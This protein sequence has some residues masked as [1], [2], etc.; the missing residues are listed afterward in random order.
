MPYRRKDTLEVRQLLL[1]LRSCASDRCISRETGLARNTVRRYR[2]W[3][4]EQGLLSGEMPCDAS[5]R[6]LLDS[7]LPPLLPPQSVSSVAPYRATVVALRGKGVEMRAVYERLAERGYQGSYSSVYRFVKSLEPADPDCTVRVETPPGWEAQVDFG[8]VRWVL[9]SRTGQK[10]KAYAFVMTL[11][12]SR[13]LY[14]ETVFDQKTETWLAC[15]TRALAYFGGVPER[16]VIDNLKAGITRAAWEDPEVNRVYAEEAEHYGFLIA[17][18]RPKTPEH[19]GKV[20]NGVHFVQ[21]NFFAGREPTDERRTNADL[22]AWCG[23][24]GLRDH[25]TTHKKPLEVFAATEMSHLKALPDVAYDIAVMKKTKVHRDCYVVF[26]SSY[27]S[28]PFRVV[29]QTLWLRAG[30]STVRLFDEQHC[31]VATHPRAS[32]RGERHTHPDH[33]PPN[34][35]AGLLRSRDSLR[36]QAGSIGSATLEAV[37]HLLADRVVDK[38]ASAGRLLR[39]ADKHTPERLELACERASRFSDSSYTTI[40]RIL[41]DGLEREEAPIPVPAPVASTF[42]R[43]ARELFGH[44]IAVL[45]WM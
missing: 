38:T 10:R 27:Y 36:E 42:V 30:L 15:H 8:E 16:V 41:T 34:K 5:L 25:G 17:P 37:E 7:T 31:L 3:S 23:R 12:F 24:V 18:C 35:K 2:E 20:E 22:L 19:K 33:L 11:S 13:H 26:E 4:A 29:G 1:R 45:P 43:S 9:D 28:A 40:K 6:L 44:L 14:A 32:D 21:R 39:L